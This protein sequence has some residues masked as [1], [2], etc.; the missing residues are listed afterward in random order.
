MP[1]ATFRVLFVLIVVSHDRRRIAHFN[2]TAHPTA[3]WT[4]RQLVEAYVFVDA[5]RFL[6]RDNDAIYGVAFRRQTGALEIEEVTTAP[7]SPWQNPYAERVI[8]SIPR[9]CL[10]HMII[11]GERHLKC[12]LASYVD[13]Y[14]SVRTHVSLAKD[15]PECR[16]IKSSEPGKVTELNCVGRLHPQYVR[17]AV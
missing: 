3:A 11:L 8:D 5:P 15:M 17:M 16:P 10:D 13:Y 12:I 6:L 9:E 7:R 1:T 4:A 2:V 14:H